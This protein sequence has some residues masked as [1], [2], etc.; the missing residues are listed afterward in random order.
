MDSNIVWLVVAIPALVAAFGAIG[1]G[2]GFVLKRLYTFLGKKLSAAQLTLLMDVATRAVQYAE[3]VYKD[4]N[5]E[6]KKEQAI[7]AA[8]TFL[9]AYGLKVSASQLDAAIEAAVYATITAAT[10]AAT[11]PTPV[12]VLPP[13]AIE[14]SVPA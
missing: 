12:V 3:Q 9:A 14:P 10:V 4:A 1:T 5:G 11:A 6:F 2:I 13:P 8:Q 7:A